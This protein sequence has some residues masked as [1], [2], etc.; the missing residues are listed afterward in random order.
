VVH[1]IVTGLL[2]VISKLC[3]LVYFTF[4]SSSTEDTTW[5]TYT[6]V[7]VFVFH[8]RNV[9]V[10]LMILETSS[11]YFPKYFNQWVFVMAC[12]NCI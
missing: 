8:S 10:F 4:M 1:K 11:D 2:T 5:T 12:L 9:F 6:E 7:T 3:F